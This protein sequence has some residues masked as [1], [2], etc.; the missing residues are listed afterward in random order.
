GAARDE[1]AVVRL[2]RGEPVSP[3]SRP[4][5]APCGPRER[6]FAQPAAT[7]ARRLLALDFRLAGTRRTGEE[8]AEVARPVLLSEPF[9]VPFLRGATE[10]AFVSGRFAPLVR[11]GLRSRR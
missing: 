4:E 8:I 1:T 2:H 6:P 11:L 7:A 9:L 10:G 5:S 3:E